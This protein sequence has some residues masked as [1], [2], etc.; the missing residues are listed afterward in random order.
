MTSF[1]L[2]RSSEAFF[3]LRSFSRVGS[4][5]EAATNSKF[6]KRIPKF[7]GI[8]IL[9]DL[10]PSK[11]IFLIANKSRFSLRFKF[12]LLTTEVVK[13]EITRKAIPTIQTIMAKYLPISA[14]FQRSGEEIISRA[15]KITIGMLPFHNSQVEQPIHK[16]VEVA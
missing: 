14:F 4:E 5:G 10:F 3:D 11:L 13:T 7:L 15:P 8:L 16:V 6:A 1:S 12:Y 2:H 9:K